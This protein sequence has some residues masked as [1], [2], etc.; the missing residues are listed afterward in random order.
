MG[1]CVCEDRARSYGGQLCL[2]RDRGGGRTLLE[3]GVKPT[4]DGNLMIPMKWA[5]SRVGVRD[6]SSHQSPLGV[7]EGA[8]RPSLP[9][10]GL[11]VYKARSVEVVV[12][13]ELESV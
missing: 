11:S 10:L 8:P 5:E 1:K 3:V 6:L 13:F 12:V 9:N 7:R 4:E 2:G